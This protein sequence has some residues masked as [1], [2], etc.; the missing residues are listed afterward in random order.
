MPKS[1][2]S[3]GACRFPLPSK[4]YFC[5]VERDVKIWAAPQPRPEHGPDL[6]R[7][8]VPKG[9][10]RHSCNECVAIAQ[11]QPRFAPIA[12]RRR[13]HIFDLIGKLDVLRVA[14]DSCGRIGSYRV[15]DLI[16][17]RGRDAKIV[18]WLHEIAADCCHNCIKC[19]LLPCS[20]KLLASRKSIVSNPSMNW[21]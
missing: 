17:Q 12:P 19:S 4:Y 6:P 7:S 3:E 1:Q 8:Q 9:R 14:C 11:L 5:R 21:S 18:D 16:E 13:D 10:G 15:A 2:K 20:I